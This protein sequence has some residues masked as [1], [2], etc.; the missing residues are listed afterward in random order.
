MEFWRSQGKQAAKDEE[1]L[2]A[3]FSSTT[4]HVESLQDF[5]G[6]TGHRTKWE[7]HLSPNFH[8]VKI[9]DF[10]LYPTENEILLPPN[11]EFRVKSVL[12]CGNDLTIVQCDQLEE[13]D[14]LMDFSIATAAVP[15]RIAGWSRQHFSGIFEI[16][17]DRSRWVGTSKQLNA[18]KQSL[19]HGCWLDI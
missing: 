8:P 12:D 14:P 16:N 2:W 10:S 5:L 9:Q 19:S 13:T 15:G 17:K 1:F 6:T 4:S 3:G 11:M 18:P 7:L